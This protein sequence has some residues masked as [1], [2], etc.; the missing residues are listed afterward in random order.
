MNNCEQRKVPCSS[1]AGASAAV[2]IKRALVSYNLTRSYRILDRTSAADRPAH[3]G[4]PE[5]VTI[6]NFLT[7]L[8]LLIPKLAGCPNQKV[9]VYIPVILQL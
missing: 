5:R 2:H 4:L 6:M 7:A 8:H 3:T 1:L 9:L